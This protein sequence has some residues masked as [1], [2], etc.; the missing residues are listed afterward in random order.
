MTANNSN[1]KGFSYIDVMIGLVIMLVGVLAMAGALSDSFAEAA[2]RVLPEMAGL[3]IAETTVQRT[4]EGV[5]ETYT[6]GRVRFLWSVTSALSRSSRPIWCV[7][8]NS[9]PTATS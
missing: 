4:S 6:I 3:K 1:Q 5:G 9:R 7:F 2:E 8:V